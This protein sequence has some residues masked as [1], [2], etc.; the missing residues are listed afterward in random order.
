MAVPHAAW[1]RACMTRAVIALGLL[2]ACATTSTA[3]SPSTNAST[4]PPR[5]E[6]VASVDGMIKAYYEIVNIAPD[7]P[8]QW[9]RDRTLYAPWLRFVSSD[10]TGAIT[11]YDH[12]AF[13]AATEPLIRT[14]FRERELARVT[15]R[16]GNIVHVDSSYESLIGPDGRERARGV[17]SL[18]LYWDGKRWWIASAMWQSE[19]AA[20]PIPPE[21]LPATP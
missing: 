5:P 15:R 8:R 16:Y 1:Q 21:L 20:F 3:T 19:S 18:E 14:G 7:Q 9:A 4:I 12:P 13:V 2:A 6:D 17:N 11:V 10:P